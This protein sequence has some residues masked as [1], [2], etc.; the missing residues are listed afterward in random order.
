MVRFLAGIGCALLGLA[1][2]AEASV[3][4]MGEHMI[5]MGARMGQEMFIRHRPY[6]YYPLNFILFGLP[7]VLLGGWLL[8]TAISSRH[9]SAAS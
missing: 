7:F 5:V 4:R 9:D 8:L 3:P 2:V 1:I 6:L